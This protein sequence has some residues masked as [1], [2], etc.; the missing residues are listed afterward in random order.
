MS[1]GFLY[2]QV[3]QYMSSL[4]EDKIPYINS[5]GEKYRIKQLLHQLPPHDNEARYCNGLSDEEKRELRLFSSR[6]KRESLGRGSVRPLPL[7]M[8]GIACE[9]VSMMAVSCTK[10]TEA[11]L[12][13]SKWAFVVMKKKMSLGYGMY[14]FTADSTRKSIL[15]DFLVFIFSTLLP[16][17]YCWWR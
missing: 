14:K 1:S 17:S 2:F 11:S 9:Q 7:N 3:H 13:H 16:W 15:L 6:R 5:V 8:E 4:P 10:P 12:L